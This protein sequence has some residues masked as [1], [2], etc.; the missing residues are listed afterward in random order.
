MVLPLALFVIMLG[1]GMSLVP[2]DFGRV[3][4][5]PKAV[6]VG[7]SL[8]MIVLPLLGLGVIKLFGLTG[9]MAVGLFVLAL[10]PGGT[11]SNMLSYLSKGDIALS[12]T[13]TAVVSLV[14][15]FSIPLLLAPALEHFMTAGQ[16]IKLPI[17]KTI[18]TLL[19][20]TALPVGLGMF[21]RSRAPGFALRSETAVKWLSLLFLALVIAGIMRENWEKL[22]GFFA[23]AGLSSLT[24]NVSALI[25]GFF[26]S[27]GMRLGRDQSVTIGIEVGIQNGTTALFI[28]GE[29]LKNAEMGIPP[30]IYSLI[31]FATGAL[32]AVLVNLGRKGAEPAAAA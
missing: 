5:K 30:A 4:K 6:A 15:P 8:Q 20:I 9:A 21:I 17:A 28:T 12:I 22:P 27:K 31:M 10:S 19:A 1:M 13:L 25:L 32:F 26:V 16:A 23:Q 7:I 14:T 24:L 2:A 18:V 29:I 11:T 3:V